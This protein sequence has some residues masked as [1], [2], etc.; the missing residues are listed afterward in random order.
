[1]GLI[2]AA[3]HGVFGVDCRAGFGG[4]DG[5][6]LSFEGD[7]AAVA[8]DVDLEDGG[9][10]DEAIDGG[11]GHGGVGEDAVPFAEG[12]VGGDHD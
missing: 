9:V 7:A 12:L 6:L 8:I 4:F 10:V 5:V 3:R 11:E 1:M 2:V